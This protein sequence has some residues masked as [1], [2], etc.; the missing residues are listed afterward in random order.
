MIFGGGPS[1]KEVDDFSLAL[2]DECIGSALYDGSVNGAGFDTV[3]REMAAY[4]DKHN[5]G[6]WKKSRM[7]GNLDM[8]LS[9]AVDADKRAELITEAREELI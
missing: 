6:T 8:F 4:S 9:Q 2:I 5:L 7:L 1:L 3:L